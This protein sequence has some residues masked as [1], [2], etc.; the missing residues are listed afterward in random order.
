MN[1]LSLT[2]KIC[3]LNSHLLKHQSGPV[4]RGSIIFYE[5]AAL[6]HLLRALESTHRLRSKPT[7]ESLGLSTK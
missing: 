7:V 3:A 6:E 5:L 2:I 1:W 4:L